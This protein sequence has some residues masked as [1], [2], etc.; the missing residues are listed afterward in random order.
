MKTQEQK[1][2]QTLEK[3]TLKNL[4]ARWQSQRGIT[5]IALMISIIIIVILVAVTIKTITGDHPI[6]GTS[7]ETVEDHKIVSYKEQIEQTI[8]AK[9]VNKS[10]VGEIATTGDIEAL[11]SKQD[12]IT[13]TILNPTATAEA[14]DTVIQTN[15]G[16]IFQAYYNNVYGYVDIEYIGKNLEQSKKLTINATYEKPVAQIYATSEDKTGNVTRHDLIH[17]YE[18]IG[19]TDNPSGQQ[20]YKIGDIRNRVV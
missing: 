16:Y 9:I 8:H 19:G 13:A 18:I 17:K 2:K 12:W 7:V 5:L 20:K 10:M 1:S 4:K 6:I 15:E 3:K 11:L 14:G